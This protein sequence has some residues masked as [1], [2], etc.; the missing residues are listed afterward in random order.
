MA[1]QATMFHLKIALSDVDRGVYEALD[2]RLAQHPS[3]TGRY[4]M[5]RAIAYCLCFEEGIT[6]TKGLSST[7]EPAVW[8]KDLQGTTTT[9]I[10]VGAPSP[11]RLHKASKAVNKVVVVSTVELAAL[12]KTWSSKAI[13][14]AER[15]DVWLLQ[16]SF[17]DALE[18]VT[19]RNC[20]WEFTRS[21]GQLYVSVGGKLIEGAVTK[22]TVM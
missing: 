16:P 14:Q 21:D 9:W 5:T 2:L 18:A 1:L 17:V 7:D 20:S 22:G 6:F 19:D 10:E 13:H 12:Q 8:V 4:L 11:E 15:I 3:E